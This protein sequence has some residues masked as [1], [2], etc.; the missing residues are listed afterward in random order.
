[1]MSQLSV[2]IKVAVKL[3]TDTNIN[4]KEQYFF[5]WSFYIAVAINIMC[6][7]LLSCHW[8]FLCKNN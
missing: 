6:I 8:L 3:Y 1:M 7:S 4:I 2:A 5:V